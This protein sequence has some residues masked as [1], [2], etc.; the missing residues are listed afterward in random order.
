MH[1]GGTKADDAGKGKTMT[2]QTLDSATTETLHEYAAIRRGQHPGWRGDRVAGAET[3]LYRIFLSRPDFAATI[4]A[5][6][7]ADRDGYADVVGIDPLRI[8]TAA[9]LLR[10][11]SAPAA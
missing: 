10:G 7:D 1:N 3:M 8:R 9:R 4:A 6:M 11:E 2:N 5:K